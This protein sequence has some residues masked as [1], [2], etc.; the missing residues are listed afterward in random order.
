MDNIVICGSSGHAKVVIDIVQKEGKYNIRGLLEKGPD[1]AARTLGYPVL[2]SEED[3]PRLIQ[4]YQLAGVLIGIG[5]NFLRAKVAA[6]IRDISP[7]LAFVT[8]VHPSA[9]IGI[10]VAIG[11]GTVIM[12][13]V[14]VNASTKI[15]KLCILNTNSTLDHDST[16]EDYASLAPGVNVGGNCRIGKYSAISIGAVLIHGMQVG[17][18]SVVGAGAVVLKPVEPLVVAY[19]SPARMIRKRQPGEKYL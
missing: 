9:S 10:D 19:G 1:V 16:L 6:R 13:G 3:L 15:G 7:Q 14:S 18:H 5:D 2:G 12:A 11:E 4:E 8:A 17:E